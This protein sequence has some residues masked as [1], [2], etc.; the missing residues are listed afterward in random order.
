MHHTG[1][2]SSEKCFVTFAQRSTNADTWVWRHSS[3]TAGSTPVTQQ[4]PTCSPYRP[5]HSYGFIIHTSIIT[6]EEDVEP[7]TLRA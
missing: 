6:Q 7:D 2:E 5:E 1:T 4:S 3:S